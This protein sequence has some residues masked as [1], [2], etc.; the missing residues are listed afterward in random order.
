M[1]SQ[2]LFLCKNVK[3]WTLKKPEAAHQPQED[4]EGY[5]QNRP[6]DLFG[7]RGVALTYILPNKC[8]TGILK[9]VIYAENL[10]RQVH[11]DNHACLTFKIDF[12]HEKYLYVKNSEFRQHADNSGTSDVHVLLHVP[13]VVAVEKW[14]LVYLLSFRRMGYQSQ[15]D[16]VY[17]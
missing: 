17:Y 5:D 3:N 8:R 15:L 16:Q 4:A 9:P 10:R 12:A 6:L 1:F 2:I 13:E 11:E 7:F 14:N